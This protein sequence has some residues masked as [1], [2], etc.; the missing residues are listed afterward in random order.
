MGMTGLSSTQV[1][2]PH[3][4]RHQKQN[5]LRLAPVLPPS[6][7]RACKR[8]GRAR[9][10]VRVGDA[11]SC[12]AFLGVSNPQHMICCGRRAI[13]SARRNSPPQ[14]KRTDAERS[15][16]LALHLAPSCPD[17]H[18][19][20]RKSRTGRVDSGPRV[21]RHSAGDRRH[22]RCRCAC[23]SDGHSAIARRD[24][25]APDGLPGGPRDTYVARRRVLLL[26]SFVFFLEQG[27]C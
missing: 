4:K 14:T 19:C 12:C 24:V 18:G 6:A 1:N 7:Q 15:A 22:V 26:P 16:F 27:N 13:C 8:S 25:A 5:I 20:E 21:A 10:R 23:A 11:C 17:F 3:T 9:A 2:K